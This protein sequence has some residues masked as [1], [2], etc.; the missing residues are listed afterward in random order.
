M[1][2]GLAVACAPPAGTGDGGGEGGEPGSAGCVK[3]TSISCACSDGDS[4]AQTC[5]SDGSFGRCI[6]EGDEPGSG[7]KGSGGSESLGGDKGT[8]GAGAGGSNLGVGGGS[9]GGSSAGGGTGGDGAETGGSG[10]GGGVATGC[11]DADDDDVCD[12]WDLCPSEAGDSPVWKGC[13]PSSAAVCGNGIREAGEFC[14]G[15]AG[16]PGNGE[17]S[18]LPGAGYTAGEFT[19]R[20]DCLDLVL[21][22]CTTNDTVPD[23]WT[24]PPGYYEDTFC[25]CG[26]GAMDPDCEAADLSACEFCL[27]YNGCGPRVASSPK[28]VGCQERIDPNDITQCQPKSCG[29]GI[30]DGVGEECD[31]EDFG[32]LSCAAL[33]YQ[34]GELLCTKSCKLVTSVCGEALTCGDDRIDG[35]EA[36]DGSEGFNCL[37]AGM[38]AGII[39]CGPNCS[40]DPLLC[41]EPDCGNNVIEGS[42]SCDGTELP[43]DSCASYGAG[44]GAV[45][46]GSDCTPDL[47]NCA[48]PPPEWVCD[49]AYFGDG[50]CDCGCG[51]VDVDC[52]SSAASACELFD[53]CAAG[54]DISSVLPDNNALC[55]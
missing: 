25:D 9:G 37:S 16:L 11:D 44:Q 2:V 42:E 30:I 21:S 15:T 13:P 23:G 46:C 7:G 4:G 20:G 36:C 28:G 22:S 8:G 19:C 54:G 53:G 17:C 1:L 52:V 40:A 10:T 49:P 39:E 50:A 31:E 47:S 43:S 35:Y 14:D 26:C 34:D 29:D 24:C 51:A 48:G 55:P 27:D 38:G 33:G 41:P 12:L 5:L 45:T 3:G 18:Q 6:C 32:G